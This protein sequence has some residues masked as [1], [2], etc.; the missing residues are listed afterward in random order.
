MQWVQQSKVSFFIL[1]VSPTTICNC[2]FIIFRYFFFL[3]G[4]LWFYHTARQP[5]LESLFMLCSY[6]NSQRMF[7]IWK[8]EFHT[9]WGILTT[10]SSQINVSPLYEIQ[11]SWPASS[12]QESHIFILVSGGIRGL[13]SLYLSC[14]IP[15][16]INT[17]ESAKWDQFVTLPFSGKSEDWVRCLIKCGGVVATLLFTEEKIVGDNKKGQGQE[18][19]VSLKFIFL[20][21][22]KCNIKLPQHSRKGRICHF[23]NLLSW[24]TCL[25]TQV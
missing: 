1:S 5:A 4:N 6:G 7:I 22:W 19:G 14:Q 3:P 25:Q 9:G 23:I 18:R 17:K 13:G 2:G 12:V 16:H 21:E 20:E 24:A 8:R 10:I 11:I 15:V